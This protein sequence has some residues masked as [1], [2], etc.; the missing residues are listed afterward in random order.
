MKIKISSF[1]GPLDL[2]LHLVDKAE[3][4]LYEISVSEI[5][6]QYMAYILEMQELELEIASEFLVMAAKL[7]EMKSKMLLPPKEDDYERLLEEAEVLDPREELIQRL[8][9]YKKFKDIA[10][11]L[12][13]KEIERSRVYTRPP[14]NLAPFVDQEDPNPVANISLFNLLDAFEAVLLQK[15]QEGLKTIEREEISIDEKMEEITELIRNKRQLYFSQ[16]FHSGWS[17]ARLIVTFL[18]LL[19]LM[20]KKTISC[21]QEDLFDDIVIT[22]SEANQLGS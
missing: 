17:R 2:L 20:K 21:H 12:R 4:D 8:V 15:A 10:V 14:E 5:A 22:Y 19:E 3:V 1:E 13:E 6:D 7:L 11:K 9:E 16:L 18:A